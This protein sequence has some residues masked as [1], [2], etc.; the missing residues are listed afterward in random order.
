MNNEI[1]I[2]GN[3]Y[4][5]KGPEPVSQTLADNLS[6]LTFLLKGEESIVPIGSA[7]WSYTDDIHRLIINENGNMFLNQR[8]YFGGMS[9]QNVSIS[10]KQLSEKYIELSDFL[11]NAKY[12]GKMGYRTKPIDERNKSYMS[13]PATVLYIGDTHVITYNND[14]M[15]KSF[16]GNNVPIHIS[17]ARYT[18]DWHFF[19]NDL[20]IYNNPNNLFND[21]YKEAINKSKE[22]G[23]RK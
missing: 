16:Y 4:L 3:L 7:D 15:D 6:N 10:S 22:K 18:K 8:D 2:Q 13:S 17:D 9:E 20:G 23:K 5:K 19:G 14:P 1:L 11:A 12:I 21:L